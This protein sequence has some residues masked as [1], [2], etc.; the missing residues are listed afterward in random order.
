MDKRTLTTK[1]RRSR[2]MREDGQKKG[3]NQKN[4]DRG[5]KKEDCK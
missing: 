1:Q 3:L 4:G 2:K 5:Q